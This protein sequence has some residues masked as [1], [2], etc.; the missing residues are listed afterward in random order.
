MKTD[1]REAAVFVL[2]TFFVPPHFRVVSEISLFF[3]YFLS[4]VISL[5]FSRVAFYRHHII[6][7]VSYDYLHEI[8]PPRFMRKYDKLRERKKLIS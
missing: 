8:L 3:I 5:N 1:G 4:L 6:H 7:F 2:S